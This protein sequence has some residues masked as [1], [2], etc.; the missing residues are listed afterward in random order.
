M[1]RRRWK[2]NRRTRSMRKRKR[3]KTMREMRRG[4]GVRKNRLRKRDTRIRNKQ[5]S[6]K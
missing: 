2:R 4:I 3:R 5:M 6:L 1:K